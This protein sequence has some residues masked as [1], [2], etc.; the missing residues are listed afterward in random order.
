MK[1][2]YKIYLWVR[3]VIHNCLIHPLLPFL[4]KKVWTALHDKDARHWM[5][6]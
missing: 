4:P 6:K 5:N 2:I 1:I 3:L